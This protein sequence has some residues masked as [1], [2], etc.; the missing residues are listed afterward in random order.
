MACAGGRGPRSRPGRG[1]VGRRLP[2]L[3]RGQRERRRGAAP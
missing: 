1:R 3:R 2:A